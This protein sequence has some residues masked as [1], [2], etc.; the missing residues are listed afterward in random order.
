[1]LEGINDEKKYRKRAFTIIF[2]SVFATND[3]SL[4]IE[5]VKEFIQKSMAE[6]PDDQN[7][8]DYN[9]FYLCNPLLR[10]IID[11]LLIYGKFELII[12]AV[13]MM[14]GKEPLT[15]QLNKILTVLF[16]KEF[17]WQVKNYKII[18]QFIEEFQPVVEDSFQLIDTQL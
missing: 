13:K 17:D 14:R 12:K 9:Y 10:K 16:K 4:V 7:Y 2:D 5:L 6:A 1:M 8:D 15:R 3:F 18:L 11:V